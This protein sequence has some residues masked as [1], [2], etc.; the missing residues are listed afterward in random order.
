[1]GTATQTVK[2]ADGYGDASVTI[3][4]TSGNPD[5][6]EIVKAAVLG[7]HAGLGEV[8]KNLLAFAQPEDPVHTAT[9]TSTLNF[10]AVETVLDVSVGYR[11]MS[12][13]IV[14]AATVIA[15]MA[16][17]EL[18]KVL[19][20]PDTARIMATLNA[21]PMAQAMMQNAAA[22]QQQPAGPQMPQPQR[23]PIASAPSSDSYSG[24]GQYL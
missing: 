6:F 19:A 8:M 5:E 20:P 18:A 12:F 13:F 15:N 24:T 3:V 23:M 17:V 22:Q 14:T 21:N 2:S 4:V 16:S 9:L 11:S 1:M 7:I 10:S